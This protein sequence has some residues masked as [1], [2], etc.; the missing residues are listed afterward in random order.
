MLFMVRLFLV[1]A[2]MVTVALAMTARGL[3]PE[4]EV[5]TNIG[6][7]P[8]V[9]RDLVQLAVVPPSQ[10]AR[11]TIDPTLS[12][13]SQLGRVVAAPLPELVASSPTPETSHVSLARAPASAVGAGSVA[14]A[15][16]AAKPADA[17]ENEH[18]A[19][20]G[21]ATEV[22]AVS[23]TTSAEKSRAAEP[24]APVEPPALAFGADQDQRAASV[25]GDRTA[26]VVSKPALDDDRAGPGGALKANPLNSPP[27]SKGA[28]QTSP[29]K[30]KTS[31][32]EIRRKTAAR[33][34]AVRARTVAASVRK[35]VRIAKS[36]SRTKPRNHTPASSPA[37]LKIGPEPFEYMFAAPPISAAPSVDVAPASKAA[38]PTAAN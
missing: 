15:P 23:P 14:S 25:S 38:P 7:V 1:A 22:A 4:P 35:K 34:T 3:V 29:S 24:S 26:A 19:P 10:M 6:V 31:A 20:P 8:S 37:S 5:R 28:E 13:A 17:A 30:G 32:H 27:G 11:L 9:G 21:A 33:R 16:L 36:A 12:V 2:G 18:A